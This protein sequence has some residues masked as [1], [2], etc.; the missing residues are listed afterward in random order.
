MGLAANDSLTEMPNGIDRATFV[1]PALVSV[2]VLGLEGIGLISLL[3]IS[4]GC[5]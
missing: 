3:L 1:V 2:V 4:P 5:G